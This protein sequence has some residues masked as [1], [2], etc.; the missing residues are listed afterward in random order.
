MTTIA[1]MDRR[2]HVTAAFQERFGA[3]PTLWAR[4]PGRVDLMGSHTDYNPRY[5]LT[6]AIGRDTWIAAR[7]RDDRTVRICTL[8]LEVES[9]FDLDHLVAD[10]QQPWS[11]YVRGVAAVLRAEGRKLRGFDG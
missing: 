2:A 5:V 11:N 9:H 1:S 7:P 3:V 4:S 6:L 8:N 10:P